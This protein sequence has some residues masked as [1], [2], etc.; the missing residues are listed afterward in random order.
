MAFNTLGYFKTKNDRVDVCM[1]YHNADK[2]GLWVLRSEYQANPA[3]NVIK[4]L[5]AIHEGL[6]VNHGKTKKTGDK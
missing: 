4:K 3:C 5:L 2:D 6:T 1:W